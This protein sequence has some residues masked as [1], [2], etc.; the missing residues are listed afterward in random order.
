MT[1]FI[2]ALLF[3]VT[4]SH[5][6]AKKANSKIEEILKSS[7][8]KVSNVTPKQL[9]LTKTRYK[10]VQ[11]AAKAPLRT[12]I[13][14]YYTIENEEEL[15]GYAVLIS[16]TLRTKKAV[17]LYAFDTNDTLVLSEIMAF[18]EPPEFSP[19]SQWMTLLQNQPKSAKLTLGKDIPTISGSTLSARTLTQAA[20][21]ARAIYSEIL[22]K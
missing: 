1:R 2:L 3:I 7:F 18:S 15:V 6:D 17:V 16:R 13:Y 22:K 5:A 14:R 4:L 12:K 10:K 20:R 9:L 21:I 8:D 11:E 19:N